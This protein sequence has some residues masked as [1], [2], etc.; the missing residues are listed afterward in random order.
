MHTYCHRCG[1]EL[2]VSD[3]S[4]SF[5]PHCGSPQLRLPEQETIA[6]SEN[7]DGESTGVLPPP[8]PRRIE[9][10][11]AVQCAALVAAVAAVLAVIAI[12]V[13]TLTF[14]SWLW[15]ISGAA[16]ALGLY[17]R[18]KPEAWV[19]AGIG[20]QIGVVAGLALVLSMTTAMAVSGVVA[21]Y[22]LH[23]MGAFDADMRA[24]IDRAA[25][26]N[27][28]PAEAMR[29]VKLPEFRAGIM[30]G[31]SAMM[32]GLVMIFSAIGGAMSGMMRS[33]RS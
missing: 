30:L 21:R 23:A 33:R 9:W 10:R 28:Q 13:P 32:A 17:Q 6:L 7:E 2:A 20:A 5:C 19:D 29:Y 25:A 3:G 11:A 4:T 8:R 15:T 27:P 31:G 18:R 12:K 26:M 16:I 14:V 22:G 24:Q 1:G